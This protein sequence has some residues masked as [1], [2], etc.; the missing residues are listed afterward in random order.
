M[1]VTYIDYDESSDTPHKTYEGVRV[2][3]SGDKVKK[4]NSGDFVKDWYYANRFIIKELLD[5]ETHFSHSSSVDHF[6]FDTRLHRDDNILESRYDECFLRVIDEQP[7]LC[8]TDEYYE[9][10]VLF[11]YVD[12]GTAPT[13]EELKERCGD[14]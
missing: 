8:Y 10:G 11:Y 2:R 9:E 13:W 12:K 14:V 3:Y 7:K 4:F 1:A 5:K 6:L